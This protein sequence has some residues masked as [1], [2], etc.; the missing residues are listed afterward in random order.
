MEYIE[1]RDGLSVK[2]CEIEA[3]IRNEDVMTSTVYTS[4]NTYTSTFPYDVLLS[5]IEKKE[6]PREKE[7]LNIM[8][9]I[10]TF[11]G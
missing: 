6:E 1:L 4:S 8:K 10:G 5:L 2:I 7:M 3:V 11:S 9:T